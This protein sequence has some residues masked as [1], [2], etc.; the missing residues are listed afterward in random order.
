MKLK[1]QAAFLIILLAEFALST[2]SENKVKNPD[3]VFPIMTPSLSSSSAQITTVTQVPVQT[4]Y[5]ASSNMVIII[6]L[7]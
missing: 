2:K 7:N 3:M 1:Y 6:C 5:L 4:T